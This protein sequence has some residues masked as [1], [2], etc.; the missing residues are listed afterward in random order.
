MGSCDVRRFELTDNH[1]ILLDDFVIVKLAQVVVAI[2]GRVDL[3]SRAQGGARCD[4]VG[5]FEAGSSTVGDDQC[6]VVVI[7]SEVGKV[8]Y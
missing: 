6:H 1:A 5:H 4:E 2:N 7:V 8:D 3:T